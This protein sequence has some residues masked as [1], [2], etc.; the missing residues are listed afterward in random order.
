MGLTVPIK[1][2][3]GRMLFFFSLVG[4]VFLGLN[5]T[6]RHH[7]EY[8]LQMRPRDIATVRI[9]TADHDTTLASEKNVDGGQSW[10]VRSGNRTDATDTRGVETYLAVLCQIGIVDRFPLADFKEQASRER[11]GLGNLGTVTITLRSGKEVQL[12]LGNESP[13]GTELYALRTTAPQE[14]LTIPNQ[15]RGFLLPQYMDLK[16]RQ[17]IDLQQARRVSL[18]Y[19]G[20]RIELAQ[21]GDHWTVVRGHGSPQAQT[22]LFEA[23]RGLL[24]ANYFDRLSKDAL[25]NYGFAM[26]DMTMDV[27]Y[28]TMTQHYEMSHYMQRYY[29]AMMTDGGYQV[30]AVWE[31]AAKS[32]GVALAEFGK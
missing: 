32:L 12:L 3:L 30:F 21:A 5:I 24:Y 29:M 17:L 28:A 15:F 22:R 11:L 23:L 1:E 26:P 13:A 20:Q 10:M 18:D 6:I 31:P 8:A 4:I 19:S 7:V 25:M 27:E 16:T 9:H 2:R 14:V